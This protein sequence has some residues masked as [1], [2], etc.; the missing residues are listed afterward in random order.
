MARGAFLLV[1]LLLAAAA[2]ALSCA[3]DY[4]QSAYA[5]AGSVITTS[6]ACPSNTAKT[7][8][9]CVPAYKTAITGKPQYIVSA[10]HVLENTTCVCNY[11]FPHATPANTF[12]L[13]TCALCDGA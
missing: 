3:P 10:S 13:K 8:C 2:S 11:E 12:V 5:A 1:L 9:S 4:T 7:L 6:A